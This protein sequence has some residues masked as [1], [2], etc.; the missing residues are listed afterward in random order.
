MSRTKIIRNWKAVKSD[1]DFNLAYNLYKS[2]KVDDIEYPVIGLRLGVSK[3]FQSGL[4]NIDEAMLSPREATSNKWEII[5]PD[6]AAEE[7]TNKLRQML[8]DKNF[9]GLR[10]DK[11]D[12]MSIEEMWNAIIEQMSRLDKD[13]KYRI[14]KNIIETGLYKKL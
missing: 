10:Y 11:I 14:A 4:H 3:F 13:N 1:L 6:D 2:H 12:N 7:K 8:K 5:I 9:T